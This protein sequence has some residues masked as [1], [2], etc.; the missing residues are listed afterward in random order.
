MNGINLIA[1]ELGDISAL[2]RTPRA[3]EAQ[4]RLRILEHRPN[5][6]VEGARSA[7]DVPTAERQHIAVALLPDHI[8]DDPHRNNL[9]HTAH[10]MTQPHEA[11]QNM[12]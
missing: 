6:A 2:I 4:L 9:T 1:D 10:V 12:K 11:S 8:C 5:A 3:R 7:A